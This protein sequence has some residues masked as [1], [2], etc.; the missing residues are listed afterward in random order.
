[1]ARK[2]KNKNK[3]LSPVVDKAGGT[4]STPKSRSGV[5]AIT[6][7]AANRN[8]TITGILAALAVVASLL[9]SKQNVA[10]VKSLFG[11]FPS[12]G[13]FDDEGGAD[14]QTRDKTKESALDFHDK[15]PMQPMPKAAALHDYCDEN[16]KNCV[17]MR[18]W[19]KKK[20][21]YKP[22][23]K[24]CRDTRP[25]YCKGLKPRNCEAN[26]GW[27]SVFCARTCQACDL[28]D[29]DK[30]C[31]TQAY[32]EDMSPLLQKPGDISKVFEK[33]RTDFQIY[34]PEFIKEGDPW[35]V[36]FNNFLSD[37]EAD[38]LRDWL[39][40]LNPKKS[41]TQSNKWT[42][43][44]IMAQEESKMRTSENA[45]CMGK[46]WEDPTVRRVTNRISKVTGVPIRNFESYQ[47][48]RYF[49]G[50]FYRTH[51]DCNPQ[52]TQETQTAGHRIFTLFIYLNDVEKGGYTYFPN[53]D[54]KVTP[55][56]GAAAL[57]PDVMDK[58]P[59][60]CDY[61]YN[62]HAMDVEAG[63]KYG[64]NVWM[65]NYDYVTASHWGCTGS[66]T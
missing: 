61:R 22:N 4:K 57:W 66:F 17:S 49:E 18:P 55:K 41:T 2:R 59:G 53:L 32:P 37:F 25:D 28:N 19:K 45:W 27:M 6:T 62:H 65:H 14:A 52:D 13:M 46:C 36:V 31:N 10:D 12:G 8:F 23:D 21:N 43:D 30:R 33:I 11:G 9:M 56:K 50:Q 42:E 38:T 1:M 35:F 64:A 5:E 54:V 15:E 3:K 63:I 39:E 24:A 44:G 51:S 26:P 20:K 29:A 40:K 48:V 34:E 47:L 58:E 60:R 16:G 7:P